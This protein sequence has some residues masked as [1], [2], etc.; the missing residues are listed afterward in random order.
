VPDDL[1]GE[2][3]VSCVVPV[4]GAVLVE[5]DIQAFVK[6]EVASFKVP[7]KVLFFRDEDYA[8]TGNEKVK[9]SVVKE[10]AAARLGITI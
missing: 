6:A 7:R 1:L 3:V 2:M 5:S 10:L 4:D 9:A 8:I